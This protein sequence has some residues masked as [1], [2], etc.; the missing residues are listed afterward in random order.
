MN[1]PIRPNHLGQR[2]LLVDCEH[3][4]STV[5][6]PALCDAG[7]AVVVRM[8]AGEDL[9]QRVQELHPDMIVI[10]MRSLDAQ[11]LEQ[12]HRI[13]RTAPRPVVMFA[14]EGSA[15]AIDRAIKAG[16]S[17]YVVDGLSRHR[18]KPILDVAAARFREVQALRQE[19]ERARTT[20]ADRKLIDRAKGIIM[21]Q[22]ACDEDTAF[23]VL[24]KLAMDRNQ[25]LADI[26]RDVIS[27][28]QLLR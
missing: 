3:G 7:Y 14:Q 5:L 6:E 22:R 2:V 8:P 16:V 20:L 4:C 25:R 24:R 12:V 17:A 23:Q 9:L 10:H 21:T 28:S 27:I 19:L 1:R 18:I 11:I 13:S 15:D 26:A